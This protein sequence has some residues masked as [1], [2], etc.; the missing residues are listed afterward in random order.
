MIRTTSHIVWVSFE[1]KT[2]SYGHCFQLSTPMLP[3]LRKVVK[4]RPKHFSIVLTENDKKCTR[5]CVSMFRVP[6]VVI[7]TWFSTLVAPVVPELETDVKIGPKHFFSRSDRK[8]WE[9]H[10]EKCEYVLALNRVIL[11]KFS[12]LPAQVDRGPEKVVKIR[13]K[14]LSALVNGNDRNCVPNSVG[15]FQVENQVKRARF[16]TSPT[17][18][19]LRSEKGV[20]FWSKHFPTVLKGNDKSWNTNCVSMFRVPNVVNFGCA[21]GARAR[22]CHQNWT[23]IF[24]SRSDRK[25]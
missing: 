1:C 10:L 7:W 3:W 21:G 18:M 24:F 13:P 17:P 9:L 19:V 4:I 20:K 14:H 23:E 6:N 22:K 16:S 2:K 8:R 5:N 25:R 15:K 11:D 12:T